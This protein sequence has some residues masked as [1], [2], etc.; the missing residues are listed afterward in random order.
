MMFID[1]R[2]IINGKFSDTL[3]LSQPRGA[4]YTHSLALLGLKNSMITP[5]NMYYNAVDSE[6]TMPKHPPNLV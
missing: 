1:N 6:G 4:D 2:G 3:T 5:L